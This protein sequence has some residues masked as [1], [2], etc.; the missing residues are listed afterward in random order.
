MVMQRVAV[1]GAT[2]SGKTSFAA[3]LAEV[4]GVPHVEVDAIHWQPGWQPKPVDEFR[5]DV[6]AVVAADGWVTDANYSQVRD[7]VWDR[8]DTVV[9]LNFRLPTMFWRLLRRSLARIVTREPLW[10]G[11][12]ESIRTTFFSKDSLFVWQWT[13]YRR[14][15]CR[16]GA[17]FA[18]PAHTHLSRI[19]LHTPRQASDWLGRVGAGLAD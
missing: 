2:G 13:S 11:D 16:Y 1:V 14:L 5:A 4:L 10:N 12:R 18:D 19:V 6:A 15:R 3:A 8:A 9:W 7:I 17:L